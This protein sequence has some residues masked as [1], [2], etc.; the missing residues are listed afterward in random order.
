MD[1]TERKEP[2]EEGGRDWH[3]DATGQEIPVVSRRKEESED[4][5]LQSSEGARFCQ[6][7]DFGFLT[8]RLVREYVFMLNQLVRGTL[9][10]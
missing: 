4:S 6:Y 8:S 9:L 1:A 3:Y 7:F 5:P 2:R 10:W